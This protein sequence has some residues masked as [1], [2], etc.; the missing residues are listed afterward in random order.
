MIDSIGRN[1]NY[2]RIAVT[3]R[4]NLRCFY[5]MPEDGIHQLSPNEILS[6]EEICRVI[7]CSA[8]LKINKIRI[9]GGEPLVR[10]GLSKLIGDIK[11]ISFIEEVSMSTNGVLLADN[12]SDLAKAGLD[13][14]NISLDT[15][16]RDKYKRITGFDSLAR[17]MCG[18]ESA[19]KYNMNTV[20]L[21]VVVSQDTNYSEIMDF[22]KLAEDMPCIIR[23]IEMMPI[24][25]GANYDFLS[26]KEVKELINQHRKLTPLYEVVGNGPARYFKTTPGNGKIGLISPISHDFCSACNRIR[27]T[28]D[29]FLKLCLQWNDGMNLKNLLRTDIS[30][31]ELIEAIDKQ[32][33]GKPK[34]HL[35]GCGVVGGRVM[36]QI[37]G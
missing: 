32:V 36:S 5:C 30:D 19:V 6:F 27:L 33:K 9:T 28:P 1:I 29:G 22:V 24:G 7:K 13:R 26:N 35:F 10:K 4:C 23:F 8:N 14:V 25:E 37:G 31:A 34:R 17:V 18:I 21:N 3:D 15:L 2:F 11:S 16:Q 20:K 12:I